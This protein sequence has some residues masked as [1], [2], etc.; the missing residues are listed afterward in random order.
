[1]TFLMAVLAWLGA[2]VGALT[3]VARLGRCGHLEDER[4]TYVDR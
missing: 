2:G 3:A 4:R 1:M